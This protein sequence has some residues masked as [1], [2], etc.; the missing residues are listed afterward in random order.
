MQV[1]LEHVFALEPK[2]QL[3]TYLLTPWSRD[4]LE[5]LTGLQLLKKF[6]SF[7]YGERCPPAELSFTH[8]PKS[9]VKESPLQ[10]PLTEF[11]QRELLYF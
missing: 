7:L 3:Y 6:P 9:T 11:P 1:S 5:K 4:L 8:S 10:V 2:V